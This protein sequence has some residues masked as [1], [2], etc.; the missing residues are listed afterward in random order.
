MI[1][2][3]HVGTRWGSDP[4]YVNVDL[5]NSEIGY[6]K[7]NGY[8]EVVGEVYDHGNGEHHRAIDEVARLV[9]PVA[10]A[11]VSCAVPRR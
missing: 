3:T 7:L 4:R 2:L 1:D 9:A 10:L 8:G 6:L 5:H 11:A